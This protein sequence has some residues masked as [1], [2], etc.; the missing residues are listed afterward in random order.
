MTQEQ[1]QELKDLR[2]ASD[3]TPGW[4]KGVAIAGTG[5]LVIGL[6]AGAAESVSQAVANFKH[7]QEAAAAPT[8]SFG[9]TAPQ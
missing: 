6:T 7:P 1:E 3:M 9:E 4:V 5:A 2:K 8:I